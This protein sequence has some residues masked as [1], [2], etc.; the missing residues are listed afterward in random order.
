MPL[1][2]TQNQDDEVDNNGKMPLPYESR[3]KIQDVNEVNDGK[4]PYLA[5]KRCFAG[6]LTHFNLEV[7]NHNKLFKKESD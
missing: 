4:C 1:P 2:K 3:I 7:R 6:S 5:A